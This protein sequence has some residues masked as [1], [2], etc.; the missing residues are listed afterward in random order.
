MATLDPATTTGREQLAHA[1]HLGPSPSPPS[2]LLE[3]LWPLRMRMRMGNENENENA[4]ANANE[5]ENENGTEANGAH[6]LSSS[7]PVRFELS[8]LPVPPAGFKG[9]SQP[10]SQPL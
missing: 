8:L 1:H 7:G 6:S 9:T 10:A 3:L 5:N 2:G 4:N